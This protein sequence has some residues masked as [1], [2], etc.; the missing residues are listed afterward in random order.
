MA[1]KQIKRI[2]LHRKYR[3]PSRS[4]LNENTSKQVPW[5]NVSG[6]WLK[7]AGFNAGDPVE[8][9]IVN[10]MLTIKNMA[11]DGNTRH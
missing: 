1:Q 2:K 5:L 3:Q 7:E 10:K 8:I 4:W 9:T 11:S 6:V